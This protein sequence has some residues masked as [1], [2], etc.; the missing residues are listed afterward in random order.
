MDSPISATVE[1]LGA[2]CSTTNIYRYCRQYT[3]SKGGWQG[4]LSDRQHAPGNQ[5]HSSFGWLWGLLPCIIPLGGG[6]NI[7]DL[8]WIW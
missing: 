6:E 4:P 5:S 1:A 2:S 7:L 3:W 8:R